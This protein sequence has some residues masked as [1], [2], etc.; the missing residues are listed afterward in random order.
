M[1]KCLHFVFLYV[2]IITHFVIIRSVSKEKKR[3]EYNLIITLHYIIHVVL[4]IN[5]I[6]YTFKLTSLCYNKKK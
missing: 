6:D 4:N 5:Y 1:N 3:K 2:V